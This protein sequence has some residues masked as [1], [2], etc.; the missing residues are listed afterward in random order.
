MEWSLNPEIM[1]HLFLL[2]GSP[3]VDLFANRWNTK[4]PTFVSPV[5]DPQVLA[6][7]A[8]SLSWQNLWAYAFPPHQLLT[9]VLT[10][11][12]NPMLNCIWWP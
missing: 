1:R 2:W 3:H 10:S 12:A 9:M 11:C 5:P 7:D 8:L 6:V 4:L